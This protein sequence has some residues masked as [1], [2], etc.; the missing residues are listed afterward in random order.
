MTV[1]PD[2]APIDSD[3]ELAGSETH[4]RLKLVTRRLIWNGI[5]LLCFLAALLI[6]ARF[7]S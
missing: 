1:R 2:E 7:G 6:V 5:V 4:H 3:D